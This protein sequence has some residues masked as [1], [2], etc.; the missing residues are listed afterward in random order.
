MMFCKDS[1]TSDIRLGGRTRGRQLNPMLQPS[2]CEALFTQYAKPV[3]LLVIHMRS[4]YWLAHCIALLAMADCIKRLWLEV[5]TACTSRR[6]GAHPAGCTL[7]TLVHQPM[8]DATCT[9]NH[10]TKLSGIWDMRV[11]C[12]SKYFVHL[13]L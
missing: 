7:H 9:D 13:K 2:E 1:E 8:H 3:R 6:S 11:S 12:T 4:I 5:G 10:D